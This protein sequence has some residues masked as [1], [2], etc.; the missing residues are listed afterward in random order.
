MCGRYGLPHDVDAERS[1]VAAMIASVTDWLRA[2]LAT[3]NERLGLKD[4]GFDPHQT[5]DSIPCV[6]DE[7]DVDFPADV[8]GGT[9]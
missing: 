5:A 8:D 4:Q 2:P 9:L 6:V 3:I 7:H 1:S